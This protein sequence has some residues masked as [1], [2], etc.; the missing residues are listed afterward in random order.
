MDSKIEIRPGRIINI[1]TSEN[2][3]SDTTVFLIHGLGGRGDQW[4]EQIKA[5]KNQ[6]ALIVPDLLGHGKS[7][8]PKPGVINPYSFPELLHDVQAVFNRYSTKNNIVLGHSYGGALALSLALANQDKIKKLILISPTPCVPSIAIPFIYCLPVF[9]LEI[10]RPFLEM[11]FKRL[12]YSPDAN[13]SLL[14]TE[15]QAVKANPMYVIKCLIDGMQEIPKVNQSLLT[16]P[17]LVIINQPDGLVDPN[18]QK[19]FYQHLPQHEFQILDHASHMA[20]LEKSPQ[21][22]KFIMDF[23]GSKIPA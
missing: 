18:I 21:V 22:N 2:T 19:E 9:L 7:E 20:L 11:N 12:A 15:M 6:Y 3:D 14:A 16:V 23:I 5:L 17:T 13:P 4:G 8:K 10:L 1:F